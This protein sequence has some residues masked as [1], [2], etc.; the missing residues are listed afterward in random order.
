MKDNLIKEAAS[1]MGKHKPWLVL[2][3]AGISTESG[4]PD[5]RSPGSGLW[6]KYDP[7]EI[8]STDVLFNRPQIFYR[9][10]LPVLMKFENAQPNRAHYILAEWEKK[11]LVKAVVTQNI[12]SLHYKAGSQKVLE[13]HGHLRSGHCLKC[14]V[15]FPIKAI[16]ER[17]D[18]G[19]IPPHCRCG[20]I[21]RPDVVLF[22]DMLPPCFEEAVELAHRFPLLVI[23]SSLQVSPANFL[24]S[25]S[26]YLIIVNLESTPFDHRAR[27]VLQGKAGE[28]LDELDKAMENSGS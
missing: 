25:Y 5:F 12:D 15:S 16:K 18:E 26:P 17:V 6:E 24:P 11:S 19:D 3:G 28:I 9:E 2:T 10:G 7:M 13:I 23:G 14:Q 27:F 1:F 8:L 20:G 4:I 22:G 21:I